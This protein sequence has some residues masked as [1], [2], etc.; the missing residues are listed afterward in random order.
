MRPRQRLL[1]SLTPREYLGY[2][3]VEY[4]ACLS[5]ICQLD[6]D[7]WQSRALYIGLSLVGI[8]LL[9]QMEVTTYLDLATQLGIIFIGIALLMLWRRLFLRWLFIID[10]EFFGMSEIEHELDMWINRY[11]HHLDRISEQSKRIIAP[12]LNALE[13][14]FDKRSWPKTNK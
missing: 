8:A 6:S 5:D 1:M 2:T 9:G 7:I 3:T 10:V 13:Q 14:A 11:I 4:Q 12:E